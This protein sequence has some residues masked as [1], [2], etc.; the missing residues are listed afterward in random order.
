MS[1][2]FHTAVFSSNWNRLC[3]AVIV[4]AGLWSVWGTLHPFSGDTVNSRMATVYALVHHG[5]WQVD[6]AEQDNPYASGT[7]DKVSVDG[8]MYSSKPPVM[9]LLMALEYALLKPMLGIDLEGDTADRNLFHTIVVLTFSTVPFIL[10][11][12][13]FWSILRHLGIFPPLQALGLAVFL[14]GTEFAGY[15]GTLNNHVPAT[16]CLTVGLWGLL[17]LADK[18]NVQ[19]SICCALLGLALGIAVTV[20]LPSAI[21]VLLMVPL[22][23]HKFGAKNAA[24]GVIGFLVPVIV[25]CAVMISISGSP[26]PFQMNQAFYLYEESY[27]RNPV[28]IDALNHPWGVYLFNFTFGKVGV[29]LLYPVLVIGVIALFVEMKTEVGVER[30]M[31]FGTLIAVAI[32]MAYYVSS[33]NNYAGAS[34]GFRWMI[35]VTPFLIVPALRLAQAHPSKGVHCVLVLSTVVSFF[36]VLQCRLNTWSIGSE[37]TAW[38]FGSLL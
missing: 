30:L 38:V 7:V 36:S 23:I 35:I 29:F 24:L 26:L 27:W 14:W 25:H 9:P 37:W 5:T 10:S 4:F 33:T 22:Y 12:F 1:A 31:A 16:A 2:D 21:F 11:G 3:I 19:T 8:R 15:A 28:G 13:I 32:L 6:A 34:F 18:K 17:A 20:D